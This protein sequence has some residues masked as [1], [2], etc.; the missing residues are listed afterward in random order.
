MEEARAADRADGPRGALHGLPIAVKDLVQ[1]RGLPCTMGSH[2]FNPVWGATR[3]PFDPAR[4]CGGSSG[5][6]AVALATGMLA[7]ADGSD[8]MGSLRNPAA[9]NNVYG[10]RPSWGRVPGDGPGDL[11]V[12]QLATLGPMARSPGDLALLLD[13]IAGPTRPS[14]SRWRARPPRRCAR[15]SCAGCASAG[16]ATGAGPM[17]WRRGCSRNARAR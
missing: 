2:T 6:A 17:R 10:F 9:W 1:V 15:R 3:N 14:R 5:G 12:H 8:E 4:S 13:V 16:W 11:F 7:L